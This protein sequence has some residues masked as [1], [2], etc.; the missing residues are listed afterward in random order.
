MECLTIFP[1][2]FLC[3]NFFDSIN[4]TMLLVAR[5]YNE[6]DKERGL[7]S[8]VSSIYIHGNCCLLFVV[9][10]S[11]LF[12]KVVFLLCSVKTSN[13][14]LFW[15]IFSIPGIMICCVCID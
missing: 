1:F 6:R 4:D 14:Q 9:S 7:D 15:T 2:S 5:K 3:F 10:C 13:H 11:S 12:F 8:F